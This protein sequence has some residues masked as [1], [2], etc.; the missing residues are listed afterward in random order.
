MFTGLSRGIMKWNESGD[1]K[2]PD[3][4]NSW[5][6]YFNPKSNGTGIIRYYFGKKRKT[7]KR[8]KLKIRYYN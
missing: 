7:W 5:I 1:L 8:Q 3:W 2:Y 6:D 4:K